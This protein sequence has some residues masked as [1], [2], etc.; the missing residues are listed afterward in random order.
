M[1]QVSMRMIVVRMAVARSEFISL[2]PTF[3]K[4][5]VNAAKKAESNAYIF[6]II[7]S[8]S[9]TNYLDVRKSHHST[10]TTI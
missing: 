5:A 7:T 10:A 9:R 2:T 8:F 6:H 3:T 4:M 1:P